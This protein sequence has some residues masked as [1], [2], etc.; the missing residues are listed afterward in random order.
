MSS[1]PRTA[2]VLAGGPA[3]TK[4][5]LGMPLK[6][7][8]P[9]AN[10]PLIEYVATVFLAAGVEHLLIS[11]DVSA[12]EAANQ[13][14][15]HFRSSPLQVECMVQKTL[16]GTGGSLK[17]IEDRLHGH[18]FWV[19][20]GDLFLNVDLR[21]AVAFHQERGAVATVG[22]MHIQ[23]LPWELEQVEVD[24]NRDVKAIH[25]LHPAQNK[26][27]TF[28]PAGLYLFESGVLDL[29]PKDRYFDL[30]DQLFPLLTEQKTPA[31]VWNIKGYCR[32]IS[33][34]ADYLLVNREVL[35]DQGLRTGRESQPL[36]DAFG[37]YR[38][39]ISP[40]AVLLDPL[41][42]G[43]ASSIHAGATI[44]GPTV[45]GDHCE[46]ESDAVLNEC[47]V[48]PH[49]R[50]GR[51]AR[52]DHCI[53]GEG[54]QVED[55]T[56]LRD[57]VVVEE[58]TKIMDMAI[59]PGNHIPLSLSGQ[60]TP[61]LPEKRLKARQLYLL[62]KRVFDFGF[63]ALALTALSPFM[64][65][66]ALAI[67]L[68]S[69][70]EIIFRQN[71][72]G[73]GGRSFTMYKFRSMVA[74]AEEL[75]REIAS[76]NEVDGPMF[77]LTV[78]PRITRVGRFLRATNL[79]EIPQLWNVLRGDMSL[80]GPRPLSMD[81]MRYNP[82]W[83]DLRLSVRPGLT[84]LWQVE[85]HTKTSFADWIKYDIHYVRNLSPWLDLKIIGKTLL[86]CFGFGN[87]KESGRQVSHHA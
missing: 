64:L 48:M 44:I 62:G 56:V 41:V 46:V 20:N 35:L 40:T 60:T 39:E 21:Q 9:I 42:I 66:I 26:R 11:L 86:K 52:L 73:R 22:A 70:G 14:E 1:M 54:A 82:F 72:C 29:I 47:V 32:R 24:T 51:G 59:P 79:D 76:S 68:D 45:I 27:S 37:L 87:G 13:L 6:P 63:A 83:R 8:L 30:Q 71:R 78:D 5:F 33:S 69:A 84:G 55:G 53:V 50:I 15:E 58:A 28:R 77:K 67:K 65:L 12:A 4:K 3:S 81:E 80:V 85:G 49:A 61:P 36:S 18:A 25:R 19:V 17:E 10:R 31:S 74:N 43:S 23:P 7:L 34:A 2:V 75:K 38:P 16:P 57:S